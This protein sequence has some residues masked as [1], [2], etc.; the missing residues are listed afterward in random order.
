MKMYCTNCQHKKSLK[1]ET[2]THK[3]SVIGLDYVTIKNVKSYRCPE[4]G[5]SYTNFGNL[6][7]LNNEL[8]DIIIHKKDS[9]SGQEVRFIRKYL[10]YSQEKFAQV[11]KVEPESL[12][13]MENG[14]QGMGES[15][16]QLIRLL[17]AT[18]EQDRQYDTHDQMLARTLE[19]SRVIMKPTKS[20]WTY[21]L[22]A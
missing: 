5:E 18:R 9:L 16:E 6:K 4:C 14:K 21:E 15:L 11:I 7:K 17:A 3:G 8:I 2:I 20:S 13:R 1:E 12:S 19:Y 10:G 22:Q